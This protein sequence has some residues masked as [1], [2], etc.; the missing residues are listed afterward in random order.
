P[1]ASTLGDGVSGVVPAL[2]LGKAPRVAH[3]STWLL[4]FDTTGRSPVGLRS[5]NESKSGDESP[6]SKLRASKNF[7]SMTPQLLVSVRTVS[8]AEAALAGGCDVLDVKEPDRGAMGMADHGTIKAI[9][10]RADEEHSTLPMSVALGEACEW[11]GARRAPDL[12]ARIAYR[13]LG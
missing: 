9:A 6:H 12:P 11:D 1:T 13:K 5:S 8:E 7:P 10:A 3:P 2:G 4:D